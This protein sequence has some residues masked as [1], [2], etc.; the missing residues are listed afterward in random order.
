MNPIINISFNK[1][2]ITYN[3]SNSIQILKPVQ[4][5]HNRI[6][7]LDSINNRLREEIKS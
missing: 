1:T 6:T 3:K 4:N 2:P 5:C 7:L